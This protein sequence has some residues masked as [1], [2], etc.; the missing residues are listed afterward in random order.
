MYTKPEKTPDQ[1]HL[2]VIE[3][4]NIHFDTRHGQGQQLTFK[5]EA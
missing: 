1:L 2:D 5:L 4:F 3:V